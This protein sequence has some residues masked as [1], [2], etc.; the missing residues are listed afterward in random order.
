MYIDLGLTKRKYEKLRTYNKEISG[1]NSYPPYSLITEAKKTCYPYDGEHIESS[2][3]GASVHFISLLGHTVK[4]ILL[5]FEKDDLAKVS[6]KKLV[7]IGKWGMDGAHANQMTRQKWS[8]QTI[9]V[10]NND[11]SNDDN[12]AKINLMA[13]LMK[14]V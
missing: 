11:L 1:N 6:G 9:D 12:T 7:L 8:M 5:Q 3:V 13:K 10:S 14:M 4:R 2:D